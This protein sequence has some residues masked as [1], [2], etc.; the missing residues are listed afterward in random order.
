MKRNFEKQ[1]QES[2]KKRKML[3]KRLGSETQ[4]LDQPP[5]RKR[6]MCRKLKF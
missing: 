3:K 6:K 2:S 4:L 5:L 1:N